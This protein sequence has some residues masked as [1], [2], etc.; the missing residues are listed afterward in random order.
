ME[1]KHSQVSLWRFCILAVFFAAGFFSLANAQE[2]N[3]CTGCTHTYS[4]NTGTVTVNPTDTV[5]LNASGFTGNLVFNGGVLKVCG[6]AAPAGISFNNGARPVYIINSNSFILNDYSPN[7][8]VVLVNNSVLRFAGSLNLQGVLVNNQF[9][10]A[11]GDVTVNSTGILNNYG[12]FQIRRSLSTNG[13]VQNDGTID[14][15]AN[16]T[17]NSSGRLVNFGTLFVTGDITN[18]AVVVNSGQIQAGGLTQLNSNSTLFM[19]EGSQLSTRDL[20]ANGPIQG[21]SA[22]CASIRVSNRTVINSNALITGWVDI[23][24]ENRIEVN[25]GQVVSPATT[26]CSC[27]S[28]E[29][30]KFALHVIAEEQ[31]ELRAYPSPFSNSLTIGYILQDRSF[32]TLSVYNSSGEKVQDLIRNE[33]QEEGEY[34][35]AFNGE[36]LIPGIYIYVLQTGTEYKT[37]KVVKK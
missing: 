21:V 17:N 24:D 33:L 35:E 34:L 15:R 19:G 2:G 10:E 30:A 5:C 3:S 22:T 7:A 12:L 23:C 16:M 8:N 6:T 20:G 31:Q 36:G 37:G 28:Q 26:N 25:N 1:K 11:M 9:T 29:T 4:D 13:Q 18:D 14:V 27:G 32:V